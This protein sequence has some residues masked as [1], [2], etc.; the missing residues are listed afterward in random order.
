MQERDI[1][2]G[3]SDRGEFLRFEGTEHVALHA[4]SGSGKTSG[5]TIPNCFAWGG[6]LV[7][8]DIKGEAFAATAGHRAETLKQDV[9]LLDPA[10]Q[11]GRSHRWDPFA[12][13]Q[14]NSISRFDQIS[15]QAYQLFPEAPPGSSGTSNADQFWTPAGRS[16]FTAVATLLA[17]TPWQPLT[18]ANVLS[19]FSRGADGSDWLAKQIEDRRKT[20]SPYSTQVV[21]GI[22]DYLGAGGDTD[23]LTNDIRK[24]VSTRLA[25]WDNPIISAATSTS[26]FDLRDLRRKPMTIYVSVSP[27]NMPRLRPLLR[28]FF[29]QLVNL[30]SDRTPAQDPTIKVPA[31]VLLDEFARLHRMDALAEAAQ[32]LRGYGLRL[33]FVIQNKAQIREIYGK[34]GAADIFDNLGA[35]IVFGTAD[36]DLTKELEERLGDNTVMFTTF[37]RPRF[38]SWFKLS[39]QGESDHPHRRPLMLDQ[40]IARMSPDEQIIIRPG[41]R[42]MKTRR[43]QWWT[44]Q[45]FTSLVRKP[46]AIPRL[47]VRVAYDD[48][49]TRVQRRPAA[50]VG[51]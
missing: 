7:V 31:L 49:T 25:A 34:D 39:K 23:R 32:F 16:A 5:F 9:Y 48:G 50:Q 10:S 14:R 45:R 24:T 20:A 41:I 1:L 6:S 3:Q 43:I 36:P 29:D 19:V 35:E 42:P 22:A 17:E 12:S 27:G 26:D 38:W 8:L 4:R 18:M 28:L 47:N 37:N 46:P 13:V 44:D 11:D 33:S 40:E 15:R 2:L 51:G 30:N 21:N